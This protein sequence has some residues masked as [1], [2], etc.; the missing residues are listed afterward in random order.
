MKAEPFVIERTYN[1]P[2]EKV[3]QAIT[4]K[5][6][7]KQW[8]FDLAEFKPEVGFEF[9]F[10][11]GLELQYHHICKI[12]EVEPGRKLTHT[13]QYEGY[14]GESF[15]TFELFAE[16]D[17]TRLRLTHTGLETFPQN[18]KDFKRESFSMGWTHII[19]T[20]LKEYLEKV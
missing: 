15:I 9:R 13:W 4:D 8:Y 2:A 10:D 6:K 11:G 19:G 16:G 14:P 18:N 20:S 1:A 5:D 12:T 17:K 3:W 7:M